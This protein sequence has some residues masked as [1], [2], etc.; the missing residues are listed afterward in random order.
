MGWPASVR[1]R[2]LPLSLMNAWSSSGMP[3]SIPIVH[4][5]TSAPMSAT[6]SNRRAPASGS[7]QRTANSR[8]FGSRAATFRGVNTPD[9]SLRC[10]VWVGGSSKITR[11]GGNS[12]LALIISRMPPRPEMYVFG[13]LSTASTSSKRLSA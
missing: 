13:S 1:S 11:P 3:N 8:I 2:L 9:S 5:G 4:I 7:R 12:M 6:K 10:V